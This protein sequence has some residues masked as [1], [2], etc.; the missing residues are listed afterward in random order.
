MGGILILRKNGR[1]D[2]SLRPFFT[3]RE[4]NA[5]SGLWDSAVKAMKKY[6]NALML[7]LMLTALLFQTGCSSQKTAAAA[8]QT[9]EAGAESREKSEAPVTAESL[10]LADGDYE[11]AVTLTGGTGRASVASPAAVTVKNGAAT[12]TIVW[13]SSKYDYMLIGGVRYEPVTLEGGSTFEIPLA[14]FDREL[15]VTADTVAMGDPHEI[16]YTLNFSS[17]SLTKR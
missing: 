13:S 10:G 5:E 7:L 14:G 8:E 2:C 9:Q 3:L 15:P 12:A 16:D 6:L 4:R 17:A 1:S 11:A